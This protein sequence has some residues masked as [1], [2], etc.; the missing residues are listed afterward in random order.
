M[1]PK[2]SETPLVDEL[3]I[4]PH[5]SE[6]EDGERVRQP[7]NKPV[8][9]IFLREEHSPQVQ[10]EVLRRINSDQ[11]WFNA[12]YEVVEECLQRSRDLASLENEEDIDMD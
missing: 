8:L 3:G 5:F 4:N 2:K 12:F 7:P 11:R 10:E 6:D 9:R 1:A